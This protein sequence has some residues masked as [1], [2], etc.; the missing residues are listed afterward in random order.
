MRCPHGP[1]D[2]LCT[3]LRNRRDHLLGGGVDGVEPA[4]GQRVDPLTVD[5]HL[6]G[7]RHEVDGARVEFRAEQ[8][9]HEWRN[10][11]LMW[12]TSPRISNG[13]F[14]TLH[15]H[16]KWSV[17]SHSAP[18]ILAVDGCRRASA[19][20][21]WQSDSH[22]KSSKVYL[23]TVWAGRMIGYVATD[24]RQAGHEK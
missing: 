18:P 8:C 24:E 23:T 9:C 17:D 3:T 2:V 16:L 10:Y 6:A 13:Y 1:F 12:S 15:S 5:V 22:L 19:G 4:A 21:V 14:A 11:A 7:P 20:P